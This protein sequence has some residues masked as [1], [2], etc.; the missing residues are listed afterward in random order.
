MTNIIAAQSV[1]L[2]IYSGSANRPLAE[3]IATEL[4]LPLSPLKTA[5]HSDKE[6][7]TRLLDSEIPC[8]T[9]LIIQ[10]TSTPA[11]DHL[12]ELMSIACDL[13]EAGVKNIEAMI[14][15]FGYARQNRASKP[16][17]GNVSRAVARL[18]NSMDLD[19]VYIADPHDTKVATYFATVPVT[20]LSIVP[21]IYNR[22][23]QQIRNWPAG[24]PPPVLVAADAGAAERL[25]PY[26]SVP[27]GLSI[28][29]IIEKKHTSI[30]G[31]VKIMEIKGDVRGR[32]CIL[33]DD[34]VDTAGTL[35]EGAEALV[36]RGG[37]VSVEANV[38]H[39]VLS[40]PAIQRIE[41]TKALT[42]VRTYDTIRLSGDALNN[43]K[44]TAYPSAAVFANAFRL[45]HPTLFPQ[46][47]PCFGL[48]RAGPRP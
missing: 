2:K 45:S 28:G 16:G 46:P 41:I 3:K 14:P 22:L 18:I 8:E 34:M 44:I 38:V 48:S 43:P 5:N 7:F 17:E 10:P 26:F 25:A 20:I 47:Q 32:P 15:Y 37:A 42:M 39:G 30:G 31:V 33:I 40:G 12:V 9:A 23:E 29:A 21:E 6:T 1:P 13:R 11:N 24:E 36:E 35:C 4:G 27:G 19:H